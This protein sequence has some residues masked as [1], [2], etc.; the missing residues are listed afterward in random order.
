MKAYRIEAHGGPETLTLG[1]HPLPEPGPGELRVRLVA[2]AL[3]H[4][5]LW[6]R[7]GIEGVRFPLPLVGGSDGAGVVEALGPGV[8]GPPPGTAVF[9]LPGVSC[10]ACRACLAGRDNLCPEYGILGESRD[11]TAAE[12]IVLPHTNVA[13]IPAGLDFTRAASFPLTFMTAWHMLVHKARL[14]PGERILFHAGASGVSSA[15]IQIARYQGALIAATAGSAEKRDFARGLGADLVL[16]SRDE[17]WPRE[18]RRW[19][20]PS[21]LDVVFDHVGEQTFEASMRLLGKGGRYV[22]CGA[23]SGF[24][25][26]TDF[27]PV[28]FKNQEILGSTMGRRADLLAVAELMAAGRLRPTVARVF[29]FQR[30]AEAHAFLEQRRALGKVVVEI[31]HAPDR[32]A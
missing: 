30:M 14:A 5:D 3:N 25:L 24:A 27:R 2:M 7:R 8:A 18:A 23:T 28:F 31:G 22:F 32:A 21:G 13:P 9:V 10:G 11:G 20:G 6:V 4:L 12:F 19:A 16:D 29:P 1:E 26:E 17:Q 15:G